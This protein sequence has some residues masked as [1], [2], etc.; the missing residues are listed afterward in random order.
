MSD[1]NWLKEKTATK[2]RSIEVATVLMPASIAN[3]RIT[4]CERAMKGTSSTT[5]AKNTPQ[6]TGP[7]PASGCTSAGMVG[8]MATASVSSASVASVTRQKRR[9]TSANGWGSTW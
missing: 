6:I 2:S 3:S 7:T 1:Q 8:I 5:E 9:I 4:F